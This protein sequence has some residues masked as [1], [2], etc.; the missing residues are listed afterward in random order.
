MLA[1]VLLYL[2]SIDATLAPSQASSAPTPLEIF[3][4]AFDRLESYPLPPYAAWVDTWSVKQSETGFAG[5]TNSYIVQTR[6]AVRTSD[7]AENWTAFPTAGPLLSRGRV[8]EQFLGPFAFALLP[9]R[10]PASDGQSLQPDIP[11]TDDAATTPLKVIARVVAHGKPDYAVTSPEIETIDGH[12]TY[13][14]RLRAL[15][16]PRKHNLRDV[17]VDVDSF[18]LWKAH[19]SSR[20]AP[21][22]LAPQSPTDVT[23]WFKPVASYWVVSRAVWSWDFYQGS[24]HFDY[25]ASTDR[26]TFPKALPDWLFDQRAYDQRVT[27][28]ESD[29]LAQFFTT[30]P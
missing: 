7:G 3:E 22:P 24:L 9:D 18:D 1:A 19:F 21:D 26:I 6:Y 11:V 10:P 25:D 12:R 13:H 17:W 2:A 27:A 8:G 4:H 23:V 29:P 14:L 16:N 30:T 15:N 20:Y 28:Q 5:A